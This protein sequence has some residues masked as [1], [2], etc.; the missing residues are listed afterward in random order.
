MSKII[1]LTLAFTI[2]LCAADKPN[3]LFI[4]A[5]DQTFESIGA[6]NQTECKT[7]NLDRLVHAG[8]HF[9]QTYNINA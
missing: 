5:D 2:S 9:T 4:F 3:I 6:L 7:P 1:L 8:T